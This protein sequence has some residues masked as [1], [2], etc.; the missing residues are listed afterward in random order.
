V[1]NK[2]IR[3]GTHVISQSGLLPFVEYLETLR[4]NLLRILVYHR[5]GDPG[6]DIGLLD[7]SLLSATP[8]QF[9][10]QMSFLLE[11][12]RVLSIRDLLQ[13]IEAKESLPP[14]SVMVT[15]DDGYRNF[16][17]TAWPTLERLQ[18]PTLLF[19]ATSS[20]SSADQLFWWDRLYQG[21]YRTTYTR[22]N[23]PPAGDFPL[24]TKDQRRDAFNELKRQISCIDFHL[25][26]QL[27]DR[28]METLEVVPETAGI[29]MN[30]SDARSLNEYGCY[31]AAHTR[32]HPILSRISIDDARQEILGGQQDIRREIGTAWPVF[33]YP[34]GHSQDC[35]DDLLPILNEEGFK[36]AMT[37]IPGINV[38][39]RSDLL[40]LKRTGL[41]PRLNPL[42]FRLILTGIYQIYATF[43]KV[44]LHKD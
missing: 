30:W 15:F 35:S 23:L 39:P 12:Y 4:G 5:I 3:F 16:L 21:I 22:L 40:Q 33:A 13:A 27:V 42:E 44:F 28:I 38:L 10:Q 11:H 32:T 9:E 6:G 29:M 43:Q 14:K 31:L 26:M 34:S 37:S 41:S 18:V 17:E 1:D 7:P 8:E 24:Q 2:Y 19:L 25:A 36:V 20:L